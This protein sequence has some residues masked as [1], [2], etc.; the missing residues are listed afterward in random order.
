MAEQRKT[1]KTRKRKEGAD[2]STV[3]DKATKEE[4]NIARWMRNNVPVK[5]TKFLSHTV[6]YFTAS[7]AVDKLMDSPWTQPRKAGEEALFSTRESIVTYLDTMLRHKLF[8]RARKIVVPENELKSKKKKEK[9][10]K[11]EKD[12]ALKKEEKEKESTKSKVDEGEEKSGQGHT[13]EEKEKLDKSNKQGQGE[14]DKKKRKVRLDMHLE[15]VF[16]D[17][18]D[19]YVWIY[20]P[21]PY[22]YY[23]FGLLVVLAVIAVCLFPLW[24]SSVRQGVYYLSLAAAGFLVFILALAIIRL[25]VFCAVWAVT[26]GHSYF[27]LLPNLTEDVGFL[28]S[29]WPLY[30]YEYKG[31]EL[32]DGDS[33]QKNQTEAE[34]SDQ[35]QNTDSDKA[36]KPPES[37]GSAKQDSSHSETESDT[38]Q[39]SQTGRDFELVDYEPE[40]TNS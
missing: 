23:I 36:I 4:Y 29:F 17:G 31:N 38:S 24:P 37:G 5:K 11:E 22:Y 30:K 3:A 26:I 8:H 27:W 28:A 39:K 16:V 19:A 40:E 2:V 12:R 18:I 15:Q 1:A 35:T 34:S 13:D 14:V 7:K 9:E 10:L 21:T 20:E 33:S 25:L 6:E 32:N